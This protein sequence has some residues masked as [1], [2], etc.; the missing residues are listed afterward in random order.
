MLG[1]KLGKNKSREI[2]D[3][4]VHE[5]LWSNRL[6]GM[7]VLRL[8]FKAT[9]KYTLCYCLCLNHSFDWYDRIVGLWIAEQEEELRCVTEF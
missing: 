2:V 3:V 7:I 6:L 8:G 5:Y 9:I 1:S 4:P